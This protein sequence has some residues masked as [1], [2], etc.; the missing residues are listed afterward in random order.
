MTEKK[1]TPKFSEKKVDDLIAAH[2]R[3]A[4]PKEMSAIE[5][6][7][8]IEKMKQQTRQQLKEQREA[9]KLNRH[10]GRRM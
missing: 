8:E 9:K 3:E 5:C 4:T 7:I 10:K 6:M 2:G 1:D